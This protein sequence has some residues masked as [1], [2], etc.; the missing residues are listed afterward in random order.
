MSAPCHPQEQSV[1]FLGVGYFSR[2]E[3][4]TPKGK[5]VPLGYQENLRGESLVFKSVHS[6]VRRV[7]F[8]KVARSEAAWFVECGFDVQWNILEEQ[9]Y[10]LDD[11]L[12]ESP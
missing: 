9:P 10:C 8:V 11:D 3:P 6:V 2:G 4:R 12:F 1:P 5:T 7:A